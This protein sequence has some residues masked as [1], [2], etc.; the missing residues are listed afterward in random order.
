[1]KY[2]IVVLTICSLALGVFAFK[3]HAC[4]C[5]EPKPPT[6]AALAADAVFLGKVTKIDVGSSTLKAEFAVERVWKGSIGKIV[7]VSTASAGAACGASF[8]QD[9][10]YVIYG[11]YDSEGILTTQY[12]T[13]THALEPND[14]DV[15]ELEFFG[16][17]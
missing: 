11:Y 14:P 16:E 4:S 15:L 8:E 6:E 12:C 17:G 9:K 5:G 1:M 10:T 13:R 7:S 3:A 2:S